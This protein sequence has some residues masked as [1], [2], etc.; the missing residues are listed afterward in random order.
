MHQSTGLFRADLED[1]RD[2]RSSEILGV[3]IV[4]AHAQDLPGF[5]VFTIPSVTA[6]CDQS[7]DSRFTPGQAH[8]DTPRRTQANAP[9]PSSARRKAG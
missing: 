7:T 2:V 1:A 9:E 6:S 8:R 3:K 4:A 5:G